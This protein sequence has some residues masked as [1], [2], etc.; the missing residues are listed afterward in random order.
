MYNKA[1]EERDRSIERVTTWDDFM[2]ALNNKHLALAPWCARP[3]CMW[4]IALIDNAD[5]HTIM[6]HLQAQHRN[7]HPLCQQQWHESTASS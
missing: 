6:G 7:D 3:Y 4:A 1:K 2:T 5:W